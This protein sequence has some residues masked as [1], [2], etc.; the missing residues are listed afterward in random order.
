ME[1]RTSAIV[2]KRPS[3][4]L[5]KGGL[6]VKVTVGDTE[7]NCLVDTGANRSIIHPTKYF[8]IPDSCRPALVRTTQRI[9]VANGNKIEP[10]GETILLLRFKTEVVYQQV[11]VAEIEEPLVL[12][13]DFLFHNECSIDVG[14]RV[15]HLHGRAIPCFL[16]D[17]L[18]SLFRI[19]L[20]S[21]LV[22]PPNCEMILPAYVQSHESA[23]LPKDMV[24]W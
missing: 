18:P 22:I 1:G 21:D 13:N 9:R 3:P 7:L 17:E 23:I 6:Y 5:W 4:E 8:K 20:S 16:E 11:L 14:K 15:I 2:N 19:R 10:L 24:V 12:G